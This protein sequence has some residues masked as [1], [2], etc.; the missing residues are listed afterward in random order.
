MLQ[1]FENYVCTCVNS[2][3]NKVN[4][5]VIF[6]DSA[7]FTNAAQFLKLN[8]VVKNNVSVFLSALHHTLLCQS[9]AFK[10]IKEIKKESQVGTFLTFNYAIPLTF[11]EKDL[12]AAERTDAILNRIFIEPSLGLGYPIKTLPFLKSISKY[13]LP[14]DD[15]LIKV[16]F[17]FIGLQ[18]CSRE[19]VKHNLFIPYLN[20]Q[21]LQYDKLRVK[22]EHF[23]NSIYNELLYKIIRKYSYYNS[24]KK[25]YI[26]QPLSF[27]N[28]P[29][30]KQID[31]GITEDNI[32]YSFAQQIILAN[33]SGGNVNGYFVTI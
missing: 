12:K 28:V 14:G 31:I 26:N 7:V 4:H 10:K 21:I 29:N 22:K 3:A 17:D 8:S 32:D 11:S 16:D 33:Q 2:F 15:E 5:W 13:S 6:N 24:I 25:L 23:S 19:V 18:N 9:L 20:A 30:T 1:W 27:Y